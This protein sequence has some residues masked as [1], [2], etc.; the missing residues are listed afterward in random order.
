MAEVRYR[1]VTEAEVPEAVDLFL[2]TM[3]DMHSRQG[4]QRKPPDRALRESEYRHIYRTGIFHVAEVD[5]RLGAVCNSIVR[6]GIWFLSGFWVHPELQNRRIGGPLLRQ[7]WEA[8]A[9]AGAHTFCVWASSDPTAMA[10]YMKLGMMPG[11]QIM[12]FGGPVAN[13]PEAPYGYQAQPLAMETAMRLDLQVRGAA[14]EVDHRYWLEE[15]GLTGRQVMQGGEPVG[16]YYLDKGALGACGW[17]APEHGDPV[18]ALALRE[19]AGVGDTLLAIPGVNHAAIQM[20]YRAGVR[21]QRFAHF[22]TTRPFGQMDRYIASGT[23]FY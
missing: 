19:A 11:H 9:A 15:R 22:L 3:T 5:G 4:Q 17:L 7:V 20:A 1:P 2:T 14:R 23:A 10:A 16:Y 8:G 13:P 21:F 12:V 18:L 6:D